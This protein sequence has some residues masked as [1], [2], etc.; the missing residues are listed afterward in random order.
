MSE[1]ISDIEL[2]GIKTLVDIR[3]IIGDPEGKMMQ[4]ELVGHIRELMRRLTA[5]ENILGQL[6]TGYWMAILAEHDKRM[7]SLIRE[8]WETT[9]NQPNKP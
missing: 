7:E 1:S 3:D 4:D 9:T 6:A 2:S 8:Y 5:A